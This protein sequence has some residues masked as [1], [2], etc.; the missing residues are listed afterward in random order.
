M[1]TLWQWLADCSIVHT[2]SR[3]KLENFLVVRSFA[4]FNFSA[5]VNITR[6]YMHNIVSEGKR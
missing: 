3:L 6:T 4:W 1:N 5:F 2:V